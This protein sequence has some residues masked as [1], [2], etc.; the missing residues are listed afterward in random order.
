M[1]HKGHKPSR[2]VQSAYSALDGL[3]PLRLAALARRGQKG[4]VD[5]TR[6]DYAKC[7]E[8]LQKIRQIL[9]GNY[10]TIG[11]LSKDEAASKAYSLTIRLETIIDSMTP[12]W[13]D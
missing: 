8:A 12:P 6:S 7:L 3:R 13:E 1:Y 5:M 11:E 2:V 4:C 9:K 10:E